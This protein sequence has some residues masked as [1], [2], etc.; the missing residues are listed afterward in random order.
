MRKLS[1]GIKKK[2]FALKKAYVRQL[3]IGLF[4]ANKTMIK[5]KV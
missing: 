2:W 1:F 3:K 4:I 5:I